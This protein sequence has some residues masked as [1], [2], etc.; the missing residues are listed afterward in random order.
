[1]MMGCEVY[2]TLKNV[3]KVG[4][5][6]SLLYDLLLFYSSLTLLSL[7]S[8]SLLSL[9]FSLLLSSQAKYGQDACNVGDEGG[10]APSIQ[11]PLPDLLSSFVMSNKAYSLSIVLFC[12]RFISEQLRRR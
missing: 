1:M 7:S 12:L 5:H 3:I 6:C 10:F 8:S 11:V 2:A 4:F 9:F